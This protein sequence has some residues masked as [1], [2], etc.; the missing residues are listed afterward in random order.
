[1]EWK[2]FLIWPLFA[3]DWWCCARLQNPNHPLKRTGERPGENDWSSMPAKNKRNIIKILH[4]YF[5]RLRLVYEVSKSPATTLQLLLLWCCCMGG[6]RW[7]KYYGSMP[8][9]VWSIMLWNLSTVI[10]VPRVAHT[11]LLLFSLP[12]SSFP[13]FRHLLMIFGSS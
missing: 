9:A 1:M 6:W 13:D 5:W 4:S 8:T 2:L 7:G 11:F 3:V 10:A 12:D